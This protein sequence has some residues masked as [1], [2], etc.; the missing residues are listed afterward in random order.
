MLTGAL[1]Y[2]GES[3]VT[4]AL[5]HIGDPVPTIDAS[6]LGVSPALAAIVNKLLQKNP[7]NRFQS[8]SQVATALREA[9]ERPSVAAYPIRD[10]APTLIRAAVPPPRRSPMPDHTYTSI[11]ED[12]A[13][14]AR[15]GSGIVAGVIV[16][17][18]LATVAGYILFGRG[19][20]LPQLGNTVTVGDYTNMTD[21]DAQAAIVNAGLISRTIKAASDTVEANHVVR[22]NPAPGTHVDKN[23]LVQLVVSNGLPLVGLPDLR[24]YVASD[25]V[26]ELQD[27]GFRVKEGHRFDN[28]PKGSVIDQTPKAGSQ[29]RKGSAVTLIISD[30]PQAVAVPDFVNMTA[31][32]AIAL[33]K[34]AGVGIDTS[35]RAVNPSVAPN[36]VASQDIAP[37]A[38]VQPATVVHVVVSLGNVGGNPAQMVAVPS[39]ISQ[40]YDD[41]TSALSQQEFTAEVHFSVQATQNGQ[42]IAQDPTA[43]TQLPYGSTVRITLSVSG[44]VPDTEG[45]TFADAQE[46]LKEYGY[47]IGK[48][49]YTTNEGADGRVIGTDPLAGT[50]LPPGSPVTLIVNGTPH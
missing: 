19:I 14:R 7:E 8:A 23:S 31:A 48:V 2:T 46:Q 27:D 3:P 28:A 44:E 15:M 35:A 38:Q 17:A 12:E 33:A 49:Q 50:N 34:K 39:V 30:G 13:R 42:I 18:L 47:T 37:G 6:Q 24:S 10:D 26:H 25:A 9:R 40:T 45:E 41:A 29:L 22:Q 43:G 36:V 4:V 1:P 20:S 11:G 5:K 32:D 16:L 21:V